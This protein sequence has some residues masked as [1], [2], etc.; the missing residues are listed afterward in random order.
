MPE[1]VCI[2]EVVRFRIW[3]IY[4]GAFGVAIDAADHASDEDSGR[5][6]TRKAPEVIDVTEQRFEELL[7]RAAAPAPDD[8]KLHGWKARSCQATVKDGILRV[9]NL[10]DASFL[11]FAAGKH[12]GPSTVTLR[13]KAS[14]GTSHVD[15][16]PG[17]AQSLPQTIPFT[18]RGGD[19]QEITIEIPA[20]GLLG[21]VRVYLPKQDQ[22]IEID[23]IELH[24][25]A[26]EKSTRTDF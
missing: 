26:G 18:L 16:L 10:S 6:M 25:R 24:S 17:G 19:W 15:W 8:D 9:T 5:I 13:I 3:P 4:A 23:W 22:P 7:Q 1:C 20:T 2:C 14:A 12:S 21:I 11:G